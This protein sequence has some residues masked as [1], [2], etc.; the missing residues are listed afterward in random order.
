LEANVGNLIRALILVIAA[1]NILFGAVAI[2]D[3][4]RV[5]SWIGFELTGI[6]PLGELRAM[7]GG[8]VAVVGILIAVAVL[9]TNGGALLVPLALLLGG[10]VVG[11]AVSLVVD[12]FSWYTVA[13]GV[14]ELIS[15]A[16]LLAARWKA[17]GL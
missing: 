15:A 11:R 1:I 2:A 7:Y 3:P 12:G 9:A 16:L 17:D 4:R 10:L 5:A 8:L 14:F 6:G 13:T